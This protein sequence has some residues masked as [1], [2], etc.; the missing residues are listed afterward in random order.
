[1][2]N[3]LP[4]LTRPKNEIVFILSV[5]AAIINA[6]IQMAGSADFST[7]DGVVTFVMVLVGFVQRFNAFGP[8]TTPDEIARWAERR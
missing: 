5:F 3:F 6:V 7:S 8:Q 4:D 1:M 2:T